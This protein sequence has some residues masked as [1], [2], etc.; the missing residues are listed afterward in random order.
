MDRSRLTITLA[1]EVLKQLDGL[2]DGA[3]IRNR[4]HAIEYV[5]LKHF[6]PKIRKALI[7]AGGQGLKMRPFTYE[8]PKAMIP[9][10]GRPVLEHI[11]E[12]FRRYEVREL[13]ISIGHQGNK[14]KQYFGDGSKFGVKITYLEQ[15]L[16][17]TGTAAPIL[18]AKKIVGDNPFFVYYADVLAAVD[19][20]DMVDFHTSNNGLVTMALTS[21][22]RSSNWG[23]VRLQGNRVYSFLEKPDQR[24]NLSNIINAGF[25]IFNPKIFDYLKPETKRLEKDIFPKLVEQRKMFGYMFAGQWFDVGNPEIYEQAIKEWK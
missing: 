2:I 14:I 23:V 24:K 4:S 5:L 6:A 15:G 22:N 9:L 21:V 16:A 7:L 11:I 12:N 3:R 19:L 8:M 1:K 20:D 18:Q 25:Y 10:N 17:E 13:V